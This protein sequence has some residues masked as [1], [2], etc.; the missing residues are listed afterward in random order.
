[1]NE[2]YGQLLANAAVVADGIELDFQGDKCGKSYKIR[3]NCIKVWEEYFWDWR[4]GGWVELHGYGGWHDRH[5]AIEV[6]NQHALEHRLINFLPTRPK[7][8]T[9]WASLSGLIAA[10]SAVSNPFGLLPFSL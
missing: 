1:M 2:A 6:C 5:R 4:E 8:K 3:R 9:N 10:A 7:F